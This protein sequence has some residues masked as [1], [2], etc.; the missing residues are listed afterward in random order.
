MQNTFVLTPF[1]L[2]ARAP[3]L[4]RL[5]PPGAIVNAPVLADGDRLARMG[6]VHRPLA[7]VVRGVVADG[8]RA[9]SVGGD[10][11]QAIG[12]MS[13]LRRAGIDPV[14]VWLDA[15]GDFNTWE[16]SPSGFLGGMP[17]AMLVGRGDQTLLHQLRLPAMAETDV[18]VSDA[19]DLDPEERVSLQASAVTRVD[20]VADVAA[21][22][23]DGRPIFVHFDVD[24]IDSSDVPAVGYPVTGGPSAAEVRELAERLR[25]T[26]RLVAVSMTT[27]ALDRDA[28]R[29]TERVCLDVLRAFTEAQNSRDW[30]NG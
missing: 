4:D 6:E 30:L 26:G 27:W 8:R 1:F 9:V 17:L 23:P 29:R 13:G 15:H 18:I 12:I 24:V 7:D 14:L 20:R 21:H 5:A 22:V 3:L 25:D 19:R 2:D 10:C 11:C 28:D 16:T